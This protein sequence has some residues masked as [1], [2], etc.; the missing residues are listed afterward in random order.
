MK[1][2]VLQPDIAV[3][4][5]AHIQLPDQGNGNVSP[6]L[7][8]SGEQV[9]FF[10]LEFLPDPYRHWHIALV[11]V[12]RCADYMRGR[13]SE[14]PLILGNIGDLYPVGGEQ[15]LVST[16]IEDAQSVELKNAARKF[17]E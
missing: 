6:H 2:K 5:F 17:T 9:R 16:M 14:H 13:P 7:N 10:R 3:Q 12:G 11:G 8:Q 4:R 15:L 1:C